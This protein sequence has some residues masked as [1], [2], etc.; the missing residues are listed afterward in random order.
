MSWSDMT[1]DELRSTMR[2]LLYRW[3]L[4][5]VTGNYSGSSSDKK[6]EEY[7]LEGLSEQSRRRMEKIK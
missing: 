4:W 3:G 2:D 7:I 1:D 6:E 5:H